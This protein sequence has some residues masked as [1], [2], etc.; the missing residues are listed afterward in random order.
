[1]LLYELYYGYKHN[2]KVHMKKK[3]T[4]TLSRVY[5]N[6]LIYCF[7]VHLAL[8]KYKIMV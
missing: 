1:M 2:K 5:T 8:Y 3:K 4:K 6:R 7:W